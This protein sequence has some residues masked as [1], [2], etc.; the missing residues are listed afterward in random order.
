MAA[1][2]DNFD[3][4]IYGDGDGGEYQ[5]EGQVADKHQNDGEQYQG[6]ADLLGELSPDVNQDKNSHNAEAV[7]NTA[8]DASAP[9][10]QSESPGLKSKEGKD[11]RPA[12]PNATSACYL[13][14]L[15][16]WQT[17]D[18]IRGWANEAGCEGEV[19]E[20]TFNEQKING[21]SKGS[22]SPYCGIKVS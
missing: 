21:K 15:Q 7:D 20:V 5:E 1:E 13:S 2:E 4:D 19:K 22:V 11:E 16:W 14:E 3:I 12:D 17:D 6:R 18:D 9:Q 8:M 10:E